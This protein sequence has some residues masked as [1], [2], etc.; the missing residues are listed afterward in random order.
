MEDQIHMHLSKNLTAIQA[1][2]GIPYPSHRL[3]EC[4]CRYFPVNAR[5]G[6]RRA[7]RTVAFAVR[8]PA[9]RKMSIDRTDAA[10]GPAAREPAKSQCEFGAGDIVA[11]Q[12]L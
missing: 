5:T 7:V 10:N 12:R 8:A 4:S 1:G 11:A 2:S 3:Q 6:E 9:T